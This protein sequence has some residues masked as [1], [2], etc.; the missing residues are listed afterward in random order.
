MGNP[1][2]TRSHVLQA[3]ERFEAMVAARDP[4]ILSEFAD[5]ADARLVGSE[6]NEVATGPAELET[7]VR[8]FFEL[9]VQIGWEWQSRDVSFVGNIAWIFAQG[10]AVL[11]GEGTEQRV[12]YRMTG[13]L[14]RRGDTWRW[15]HFHGSE[16]IPDR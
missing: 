11:R 8:R 2:E 9:P 5:E 7:L 14:E 3:L 10:D 6:A 13:V 15:R 12:P 4:A 1:A 16:P